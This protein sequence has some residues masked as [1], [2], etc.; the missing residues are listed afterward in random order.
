MGGLKYFKYLFIYGKFDFMY[1]KA[2]YMVFYPSFNLKGLVTVFEDGRTFLRNYEWV[3]FFDCCL[4]R[5]NMSYEVLILC[6]FR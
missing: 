6:D 1:E 4:I 5:F 2:V 3:W